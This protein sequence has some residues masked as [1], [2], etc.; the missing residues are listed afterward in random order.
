MSYI[1]AEVLTNSADDSYGRVKVKSKGVWK[2]SFLIPS[3]G[4]NLLA[5][6]DLVVVDISM[7]L[8]KPLI[9]GKYQGEKQKSVSPLGE[10]ETV[11]ESR[12][13]GSW[14]QLR[15][16]G[17][18]FKFSNSLGVV[19]EASGSKVSIK[20]GGQDLNSLLKELI[21][22]VQALI[23]NPPTV[24][25]PLIP[26]QTTLTSKLDLESIKFKFNSMMK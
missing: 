13:G 4:Y 21:D 3:V 20:A 18:S 26:F 22:T 1:L 2:E 17:E 5:P 19:I 11:W 7:G 25:P 9:F 23:V 24:A 12:R 6:G 15:A 16:D 10:G 14:S 8:E